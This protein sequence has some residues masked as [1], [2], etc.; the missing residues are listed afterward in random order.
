MTAN[1]ALETVL[2]YHRATKHRPGA[3]ARGPGRMDW[4]NE[5]KPFRR[6]LGSKLIELEKQEA[7][8]TSGLNRDGISRFFYSSLAI[9]AWKSSG[10]AK[11]SLRV[12]PSSGDLHPT[13][14]YLICSSVDGIGDLPGVYHYS[15][16]VH[17]L[18]LISEIP[19]GLWD[20][21]CL[22]DDAFLV[23]LSS[24][25]WKEAWKYG[26]RAFR[27]C[28]LDIGHAIAA[29]S[30]SASCLGWRLELL[31]HIGTDEIDSILS[32]PVGGEGETER[33]D[34]LLVIYTKGSESTSRRSVEA[35]IPPGVASE[36]KGLQHQGEANRLSSGHVSWSVIDD[37]SH[38]STKPR[39]SV[40]TRALE[41]RVQARP[42]PASWC[43]LV[44]KRRS[45]QSMDGSAWMR[46]DTF[47]E[48]L[49]GTLPGRISSLAFPWEPMVDL[50]LFVHRVEGLERGVYLFSRSSKGLESLKSEL[51]DDL[52]WDKPEG[53]PEGM[54]LYSLMEGDA[55]QFSNF[56]S[57]QQ[58]IA[59]EGCF[60][61]AMLARFD[62]PLK[63]FGP[64]FYPRLHWECGAV[65]QALYLGA[66]A[67]GF[68]GCGI[69]C[70]L[71]DVVHK[72]IGLESEA[73]QDLYHFTIGKHIE[74]L[75]LTTLPAYK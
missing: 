22:E 14:S 27:Y 2:E 70:F 71:D 12:N 38:A 25:F 53:C 16:E 8:G 65:G 17:G 33:S 37:V 11:W 3:Y 5:P 1:D 67:H 21:L 47:C 28:M 29:L 4:A 64:W 49:E 15:P 48:I 10:G 52:S 61:A 58:D 55:R 7:E 9:S 31:D 43:G 54:Q 20:R 75:R 51:R 35:P 18:E 66:E 50:I 24:I 68:R 36:F 42:A 59:S 74:D 41:M 45:A 72:L 62:G 44:R 69:G 46:Q 56:A 26:E 34:C 19:D 39:T 57:C 60:C 6:Y 23:G 40:A 13:E 32:M 63:N 73:H 30:I